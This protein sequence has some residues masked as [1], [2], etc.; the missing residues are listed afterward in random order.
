MPKVVRRGADAGVPVLL[1]H[2]FLVEFNSLWHRSGVVRRLVSDGLEVVLIVEHFLREAG[3]AHAFGHDTALLLAETLADVIDE[4]QRPAVDIVAAKA[5]VAPAVVAAANNDRVRRL[6]LADPESIEFGPRRGPLI[7]DEPD[8]PTLA[9]LDLRI[10]CTHYGMPHLAPVPSLRLMPEAV[11]AQ[12]L[13]LSGGRHRRV[14]ESLASR[15]LK[16]AVMYLEDDDVPA[17]VD[18]RFAGYVSGFLRGPDLSS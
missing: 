12:T 15:L 13:I 6:V 17:T 1:H 10:P 8:G 7:V 14:A 5:G 4:L 18:P 3:D 9:E 16:A 2:G 11:S